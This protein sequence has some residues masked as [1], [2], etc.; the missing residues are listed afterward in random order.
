MN[1]ALTPDGI[2]VEVVESDYGEYTE[3]VEY[4]R[5]D[6]DWA[7]YNTACTPHGSWQVMGD[8]RS[9]HE[10]DNYGPTSRVLKVAKER[11]V[12]VVGDPETCCS[13]F[14]TATLAEAKAVVDIIGETE[15]GTGGS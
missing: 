5:F 7:T 2:E 8:L 4:K 3:P 10:P 14:Y 12:S 11:G 9:S 15:G 1:K 6:I 13:Y